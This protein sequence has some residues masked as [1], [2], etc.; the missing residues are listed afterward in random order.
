[1]IGRH[2]V[3]W[4]QDELTATM[5][6]ELVGHGVQHQ[7]DRLTRVRPIDAECEAYLYEETANQDL[8][9]G[10]HSREMVG[11]RRMLEERWCAD[12][13]A[14]Q[15]SHQPKSLKLWDVL[16]PNIPKLF[17]LFEAYLE[18]AK[19]AGV[20]AEV[21][22]A[23]KQQVKSERMRTLRGAT[24]TRFYQAAVTL[25]DGGIDTVPNATEAFRYF[26]F[27]AEK[28]HRNAWIN[29]AYMYEKGAGITQD[30][31]EA[32]HWYRRAAEDGHLESQYRLGRHFYRV[33]GIKRDLRA[34]AAW[35]QKAATGGHAASQHSHG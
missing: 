10:K 30:F 28:G 24:A 32:V 4:P 29:V 27:A 11:F 13:K 9:L 22:D 17:K 2:G 19:Q 26:R 34:A 25:R 16:N 8:A 1:M 7:R 6:H 14:Y 15:R 23:L 12:F 18:H 35:V 21:I 20:T 31:A 5:T 33:I 3:K